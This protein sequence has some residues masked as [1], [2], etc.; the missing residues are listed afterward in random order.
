MSKEYNPNPALEALKWVLGTSV[1]IGLSVAATT[2]AL[3]L[4]EH[5]KRKIDKGLVHWPGRPNA[6]IY[7]G[8][9]QPVHLQPVDPQPPQADYI[10]K[11]PGGAAPVSG[12]DLSGLVDLPT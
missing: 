12:V 11:V 1:G 8:V 7:L 9:P 10:V 5:L 3:L 6:P 4:A 2:T